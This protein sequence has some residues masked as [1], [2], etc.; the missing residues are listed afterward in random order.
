MLYT[1]Q[2]TEI[3]VENVLYDFEEYKGVTKI[4]IWNAICRSIADT[5]E[6]YDQDVTWGWYL[7][8]PIKYQKERIKG[9][10]SPYW[11]EVR[12]CANYLARENIVMNTDK[13]LRFFEL[14]E[15]NVENKEIFFSQHVK[16]SLEA[17]SM[18]YG[19]NFILEVDFPILNIDLEINSSEECINIFKKYG[20]SAAKSLIECP[21]SIEEPDILKRLYFY[22]P[23]EVKNSNNFGLLFF[24]NMNILEEWNTHENI[25]FKLDEIHF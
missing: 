24:M 19:D 8:Y 23:E 4:A 25:G 11:S 13:F 20:L 21:Y 2:Y 22:F 7:I 16:K 12:A 10:N 17:I 3:S 18:K 5:K 15:I 9:D 6:Q 14:A 1:T